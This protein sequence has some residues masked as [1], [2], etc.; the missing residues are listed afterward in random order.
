[1]SETNRCC[2]PG[3]FLSLTK[4]PPTLLPEF[5]LG[6]SGRKGELLPRL[7]AVAFELDSLQNHG[8]TLPYS[9]AHGAQCVPDARALQLQHCRCHQARSAGA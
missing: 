3:K 9:N 6:L 4:R 2:L 5:L 1:V 7:H 8:D